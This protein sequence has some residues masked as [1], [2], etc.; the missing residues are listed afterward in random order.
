MAEKISELLND[1]GWASN[2]DV[3]RPAL[4]KWMTETTNRILELEHK[5]EEADILLAEIIRRLRK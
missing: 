1:Y 4:M 3:R 5:M 2:D